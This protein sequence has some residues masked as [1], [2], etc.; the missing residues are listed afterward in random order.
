MRTRLF[1]AAVLAALGLASARADART[2]RDEPYS[3][4]STWNTVIRMVRVEYGFPI[5][6]RDR[7]LGYFT[8]QYREGR[9]SL[10]GSVELMRSEVD[11]RPCT[12]V[13][14]HIAGMPNYVETMLLTHL[15]RKLRAELGE[16]PPAPRPPT[17]P[18]AGE[19][20]PDGTPT[21]PNG[22]APAQPAAPT[23]AQ[24]AA[25]TSSATNS[26]AANTTVTNTAASGVVTGAAPSITNHNAVITLS[27]TRWEPPRH[28][29][30]IDDWDD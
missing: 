4:D 10:P 13:V 22:A 27:N 7:E 12:R 20:P 6:E 30:Y 1:S 9:R 17:L 28:I 29:R 8:F 2:V 15:S 16:P 18:A 26:A 14:M 3:L 23:P 11:G 21:P 24:P 19:H 25:P 5:D